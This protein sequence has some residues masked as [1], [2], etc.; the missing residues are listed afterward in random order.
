MR[1]RQLIDDSD[2]GSSSSSVESAAWLVIILP[3]I[4]LARL[5]LHFLASVS[6]LCL[7]DVCLDDGHNSLLQGPPHPR[8]EVFPQASAAGLVTVQIGKLG[9]EGERVVGRSP[10]QRLE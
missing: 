5:C 10:L 6:G 4:G 8:C 2:Q 1:P 3:R 9:E 7:L